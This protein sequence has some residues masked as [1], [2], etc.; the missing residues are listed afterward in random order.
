MGVPL[1]FGTVFMW[2][3]SQG[4]GFLRDSTTQGSIYFIQRHGIGFEPTLGLRVHYALVLDAAGRSRASMV[5]RAVDEPVPGSRVR[6]ILA[7]LPV[8]PPAPAGPARAALSLGAS[9]KEGGPA[10]RPLLAIGDL[11]VV[12]DTGGAAPSQAPV[13]A[14]PSAVRP[15]QG[16]Q[17]SLPAP[18]AIGALPPAW[19]RAPKA[20]GAEPKRRRR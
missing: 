14:R 10:P 6:A 1:Y 20:E 11:P 4:F 5:A 15:S 9:A 16:P 17:S 7:A 8:P 3:S 18:R 2:N 12:P 19:V 13:G